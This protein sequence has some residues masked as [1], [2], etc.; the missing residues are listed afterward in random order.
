M[1]FDDDI[2]RAVR[3]QAANDRETNKTKEEIDEIVTAVKVAVTNAQY[4]FTNS[5]PIVLNSKGKK[6]FVKQFKGLYSVENILCQCIKQMLDRAFSIKYPNRNKSVRMLFGALTAIKQMSDFTIVKF[7]F[8]DYFN[9]VSAVYVFEK[10]IKVKLSDRFEIDLI[11]EFV[12]KTK[13]AYAGFC[14]S[15]VI[16]EIIAKHFDEYIRQAF[17]DKGILFFERYIDDAVIIFN[18]HIEV[19]E[20]HSILQKAIESVFRD[21]LINIKPKCKTRLN[22]SKF[23][24]ISKRNMGSDTYSF[25]YLGYEYW[26]NV[27]DKKVK[28]KYGITQS[29]R[30]KYNKR[31]DELILCYTDPKHKDYNNLELL[32]HRISTF[33]SRSVYL[34]K[35]F[36]SHIWI[37]RGFITNYGELRCILD[38]GLLESDTKD[39]LENMI[40]EAFNRASVS[41]PYFIKGSHNKSGYNL[42]ENMRINKTLLLVEHIGYDYHSLIKLCAQIGISNTD[43]NGKKQSYGNLVRRYLI[44]TK[45]GC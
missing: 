11:K 32:R 37:V 3:H 9:S 20:C 17:I 27:Q 5:E 8:K 45:V 13:F 34:S 40:E 33:S 14:T 16:A 23:I 42:L 18:E 28:I 15:N 4:D 6:R 35:R 44:E 24:Y 26:L 43:R 38:T 31:L 1:R 12:V 36:K 10:F 2:V 29:K 7:D 30:D 41:V 19:S 22:N 21:K 25:D 39:F